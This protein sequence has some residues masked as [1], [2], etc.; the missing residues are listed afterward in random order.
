[1]TLFMPLLSRLFAVMALSTVF[2][3]TISAQN[4]GQDD[5]DIQS[6]NDLQITIPV[7]A[8]VDALLLTTLRLDQNLGRVGEGRAGFGFAIKPHRSFSIS[9]TYQYIE[10]RNL[11]GAF[12][13]EHRYTLRGTYKFPIKRFGFSHRSA[14]EYR[15]RGSGNS[16]RYRAAVTLEKELPES[17]IPRSKVFVNEE[18]FYVSTTGKFSRNRFTIGLSTEVTSHFTFE[19]YYL[20]QNDGFAHP[21]DLNIIGTNLKV[22]P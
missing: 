8:K 12:R 5:E 22:S 21:G 9:P 6:W 19:A 7:N 11:L 13:T 3:L 1:M 14:Y 20:R 17:F 16:W 15:K 4:G 10:T 2:S 18:I